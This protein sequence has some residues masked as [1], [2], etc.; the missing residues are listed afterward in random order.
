M[1]FRQVG[2]VQLAVVGGQ[3]DTAMLDRD[4]QGGT[5]S[6]EEEQQLR[7][8]ILDTRGQLFLWQDTATQQLTRCAYLSTTD[9]NA[10]HTRSFCNV[11]YMNT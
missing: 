2:V 10:K 1:F 11:L 3:L 9:S 6:R 7:V 5:E 4:Q 8:F